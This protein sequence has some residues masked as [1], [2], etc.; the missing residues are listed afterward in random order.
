MRIRTG[1][2]EIM[3]AYEREGQYFGAMRIVLSDGSPTV[4]FGVSAGGYMR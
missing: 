4:E 1:A 2:P 3:D